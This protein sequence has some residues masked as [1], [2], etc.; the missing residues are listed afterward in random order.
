MKVTVGQ[1]EM[2]IARGVLSIQSISIVSFERFIAA[3]FSFIIYP[4][5]PPTPVAAPTNRID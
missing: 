3:R 2:N 4:V 5:N 1:T